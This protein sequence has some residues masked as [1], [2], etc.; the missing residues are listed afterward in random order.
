MDLLLLVPV[1]YV[2]QEMVLRLGAVTGAG[3]ARLILARLASSGAP[4]RSAAVPAQRADDRHRVHRHHAGGRLS[5]R[6]EGHRRPAR[7]RGDH[8]HGLHWQLRRFE[9]VAM[10]LCAGSLLLLPLYLLSHPSG[11]R[12]AAGFAVP[13][14]PGNGPGGWPP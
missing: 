14:L 7:G 10:T 4:S 3:H 12:M 6:A 5:R 11:A 8:L 13:E 1:I 9:R 2:N